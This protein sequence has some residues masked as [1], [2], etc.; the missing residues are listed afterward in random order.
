MEAGVTAPNRRGLWIAL[1]LVLLIRIP[2]LSQAIQGD[3]HQ[4][5]TEAAHAQID[6]LHPKNTTYV[7]LGDVVDQR[8][9][10]HP[11]LN[12]WTLAALLAVIGE[13]R[14]V[15]FHAAYLVYSAIAVLAMWSLARRFSP[16]PLWATLLFIAVP[17][18][19]VNGASLESDLPFL[20]MW[21]AA[22]ALFCA[23]RWGWSALAMALASLAAY[24][25]V[26]LIPILAVYLWLH[27]RRARAAWL[28]L[29]TPAV[30]LIGWQAFERATTGAMPVAIAGGYFKSYNL[31]A[32]DAKLRNAIALTGH[33]CFLVFP[34]LLPGTIVLAWR[35]RRDAGTHFLIAWIA[36]FFAGALVLFF[37]GSAR[38]LLP[39][40]APVALLASRLPTRWLAPAV[41]ANLAIGLGLAA[42]NAEHW[43]AYRDFARSH[44]N[45]VDGRHHVWVDGLWGIRHYFEEQGALPLRKG[46]VVP[47]GDAV[48]TSELAKSVEL[49]A[50]VAPVAEMVI[51]PAIPL[52]LIGL[53]T[54]SG[55]SSVGRGLWPFGVSTGVIDRVRAV[56]V[57][58]RRPTL[59]YLPMD[60]PEAK[61]HIVSGI[62]SLEDHH[63]WM[64]KIASVVLKA[65][66]EPMPLRVVFAIHP[67]STARHVRLLLDGREVAAQTYSGP[68]A[69]TLASPPVQAASNVAVVTIEIDAT[70][71]APPDTRDLGIVLTAVGFQR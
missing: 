60:A 21:M 65:P 28:V 23:A 12:A 14:E 20:A 22:V 24:Q 59:E 63:R 39:M 19:V 37:A 38:Y 68:G 6:P 17:A 48:V 10:P 11:P 5:L 29:F 33:A 51:R 40:A 15:P 25:A 43:N 42:V 41:A 32:L 46:Q 57:A 36:L 47:P 18:F 13:V 66:A 55:Y 26:F 35:K 4:Y 71:T 49:N 27:H 34:A 61:D 2:F 45:L 53:E 8:G 54:A 31:Q 3:E 16:Q 62:F 52:R 58:E 9:Q 30:V 70:F 1:A 44:R 64:S 67:K 69:Y 7:F 56:V 50:P